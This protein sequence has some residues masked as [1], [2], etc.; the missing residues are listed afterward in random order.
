MMKIA[1]RRVYKA[2]EVYAEMYKAWMDC[3]KTHGL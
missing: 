1:F 2:N 3:R